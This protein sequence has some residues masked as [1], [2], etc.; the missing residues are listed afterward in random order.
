MI[1]KIIWFLFIHF[2]SG[3]IFSLKKKIMLYIHRIKLK[4]C[5]KNVSIHPNVEIRNHSNIEIGNNVSINHNT[6]LY[7]GGGIIIGDDSMLSYYVT[8]L[9]DSRTFQGRDPLKS[10]KRKGKRIKKKTTIGKDVWV[11]TKAVVMPGVT[12]GDHSIVAAGS[13]VTKDVDQWSIVGG[14]PAKKIGTRLD[15]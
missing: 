1:K 8:I 3:R 2:R 10:P 5:G 14:N 9:S 13:V 6:E 15:D 11:G 12:L 7:G 4:S